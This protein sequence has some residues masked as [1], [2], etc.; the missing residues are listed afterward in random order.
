MQVPLEAK[1]VSVSCSW[2]YELFDVGTKNRTGVFCKSSKY[3]LP[4]NHL[5]SFNTL[6]QQKKSPLH[7]FSARDQRQR[8]THA[9]QKPSFLE[10]SKP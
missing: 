1:G 2:S 5:S 10:S 8:L 9:R 3:S 6:K 4:F 7:L